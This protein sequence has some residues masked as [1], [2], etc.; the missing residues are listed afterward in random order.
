[1]LEFEKIRWKNFLSTGN[2][3]TEVQLN[4]HRTTLI[5]G[6]NGAG[7]STLLDAITYALFGKPFRKINK[8]QLHNS[9]TRKGLL[10]ECE[11]KINGVPYVLRRGDRPGIFEVW[12]DGKLLNQNAKNTEY[13][14]T[15]E[16]QIIKCN[17]KS[18]CQIVIL[19]SA[20]YSPFMGLPAGN[21]REIIEDLL[22]LQVFTIMNKLLVQKSNE[23]NGHINQVD[24]KKQMSGQKLKLMRRHVQEMQA[25]VDQLIHEKKENIASTEAQIEATGHQIEDLFHEISQLTDSIADQQSISKKIRSLDELRTKITSKIHLFSKE[26]GFFHDYDN[27]PTCQQTIDEDFKTTTIADRTSKINHTKE[28]LA[29]LEQEYAKTSK[30]MQE[31]SA[32]QMDVTDRNL[33]L[34]VLNTKI[35]GWHEYV[36]QLDAEIANLNKT[37]KKVDT[38]ELE[39][40]QQEIV[41]YG[42]TLIELHETKQLYQ[43]CGLLLKDGG[44]KSKIVRQYVPIINKLINKYLSIMDFFVNFELNESFEETIKSRHRDEFSYGSFSEGEKMRINLAILFTWRAVSKLR[45]SINTNLLIMDEVLDG[46]IDTDAKDAF[47]QILGTMGDTNVFV[48]SHMGDSLFEKFDSVI[49]FE[50]HKNFSKMVD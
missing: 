33:E 22:D 45:N 8:P 24:T 5:V 34:K 28:G 19:G 35:A 13:Q 47:F 10:V 38:T 16:K 31:I 18:F 21:R 29:Q 37:A 49:K 2:Q 44:I 46:S 40:V 11:L 39:A 43:V 7:K 23:N 50:K 6:K 36:H 9:I 41:S 42:D 27:C 14:E 48:I 4:R 3:W 12:Q 32:V 26:V 20:T 1:M 15:L 25:N 17:F 30:R